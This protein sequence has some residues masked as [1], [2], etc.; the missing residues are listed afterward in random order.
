MD[1]TYL[2]HSCFK[3]KG[4]D[5][6]V[7]TD[8]YS[9]DVGFS[10]P[11]V[12][13]E[14]VTVSHDHTDHNAISLVKGT[15][16]RAEP[17]VISAPGEYEIAGTSVFG[18]PSFHDDEMGIKRGKNVMYVIHIDGI[19]IAH[20]GDLGHGLTDKQLEELDG[21]DVLLCPVGGMYTIDPKK[22]V[23]VI[24]QIQPS[25]VI[26]MHYKTEKHSEATYGAVSSLSDFLSAMG[27]L[28]PRKVDKLSVSLLSMPLETEV[29][30]LET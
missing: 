8:P 17:F 23:E 26:P 25:Y 1:I 28:E 5:A 7:V 30:V 14:I 6:V 27:T 16:R 10:M 12:T 19:S 9:K 15:T 24:A 13:A 20:L 18:V 11:S 3:L 4:K 2:G 29:I 22:A 21:V